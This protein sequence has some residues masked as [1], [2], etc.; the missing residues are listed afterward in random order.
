MF[1]RESANHAPTGF[2]RDA[3][4]A[5]SRMNPSVPVVGRT[6]R[7]SCIRRITC[8]NVQIVDNH[9]TS[10]RRNARSARS[11][12]AR[13]VLRRLAKTI[14]SAQYV[15]PSST[16]SAPN[17]VTPLLP[18]TKFVRLVVL[19]F[20]NVPLAPPPPLRKAALPHAYLSHRRPG[21]LQSGLRCGRFLGQATD[22]DGPSNHGR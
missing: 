5:C 12:F 21:S 13:T 18:Q 4:S 15:V 2:A 1:T 17:V 8:A 16:L 11:C 20:R 3:R 14:L 6:S 19:R 7:R 22:R 9:C 10:R